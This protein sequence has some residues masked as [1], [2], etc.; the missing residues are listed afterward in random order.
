MSLVK[1]FLKATGAYNYAISYLHR[2]AIRYYKKRIKGDAIL[3]ATI[4]ELNRMGTLRTH[5]GH[6]ELKDEN[7]VLDLSIQLA[8]TIKPLKERLQIADPNYRNASFLDAG[9]PDRIVLRSIKCKKGV[10]LNIMDSCVRQVLSVGGVPVKGDI[11]MMPFRDKSFDYVLCFETLEHLEN[12][13]LGLRELSRVCAQKIFIS[14][15]WVKKTRIHE[16]NYV[17]TSEP[18]TDRH[19]FELNQED[20]AKIVTHTDLK[21]T[22]YKEIK[23]FPKIL[24]PIDNFILRK[25]Y[26]P[27]FFP[28]FQ[29]YE[30]TKEGANA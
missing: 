23:L 29:F 14:I 2:I 30:L 26:Y 9:D 25:F 24:N 3:R 10:S 13:I 1:S 21:I 11:H 8:E 16:S 12:P 19:I 6:K 17:S 27:S 15:P 18:A 28:K 4:E 7:I 22:Y 20:F 5:Y